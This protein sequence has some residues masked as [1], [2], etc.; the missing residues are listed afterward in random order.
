MI[1]GALSRATRPEVKRRI[2]SSGA[3]NHSLSMPQADVIRSRVARSLAN[4]SGY[5]LR[6]LVK[7]RNGTA[8]D[9]EYE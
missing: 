7:S 1:K 9:V 5:R 8:R 2:F 3:L 4:D 6:R